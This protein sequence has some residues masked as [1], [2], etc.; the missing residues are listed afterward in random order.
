MS[1][2]RGRV[3]LDASMV[4]GGGGYTHLANLLPELSVAAPDLD[5]ILLASPTHWPESFNSLPNLELHPVSESNMW[6]RYF[7]VLT[8]AG[9]VARRWRSDLYFSVAEYTPPFLHCPAIASFRNPNVFTKLDQGWGVKQTLRLGFL[10]RLASASARR[11]DRILF[12]SHDSA[13]WIGDR[14]DVPREK[15][16]VLHH[17][18]DARHFSG[19]S[20]QGRRTGTGVLSVSS[21]YRY[22]NFV[23]LIE[24]W[25][26]WVQRA[27]E[28]SV[29]DLTI[30]GDE[31]D[32]RYLA[33]M[34]EAIRGTG[35]HASR[36]HL[37]G[38]VPYSEIA[39]YYASAELFVFPSYLETFGHPLVE[40]LA[41]GLPVVAAD[42]PVFR[43]IAGESV[44]YA[45]PN[46]SADFSRAM[47]LAIRSDDASANR[48]SLAAQ[49][50]SELSWEAN[51]HQLAAL[52]RQV[53]SEGR[54]GVSP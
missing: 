9:R 53:I 14:L 20:G 43:E 46:D 35:P 3:L 30:I 25:H 5:F 27:G 37:L 24:A 16:F 18:I 8:R 45:D 11:C 49:R 36:I 34:K 13:A 51:A 39:D 54:G 23:R 19:A 4:R 41:S 42:I 22:K 21:I 15:R 44:V 7:F 1:G 52:F 38:S 26:M 2:R 50:V 31:Q 29:P 33:Q 47:E 17:G 6:G 28:K 10:R 48:G 40:A 32:D 12:V